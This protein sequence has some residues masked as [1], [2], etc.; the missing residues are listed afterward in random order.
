M[1]TVKDPADPLG[2]LV[3][4]EQPVGLNHLALAMDPLGLYRTLS[5]GLCFLGRRQLMILTPEPPSL[6]RR[7]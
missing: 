1:R 4:R 2:Q 7:L 3:S 5:H 6:T